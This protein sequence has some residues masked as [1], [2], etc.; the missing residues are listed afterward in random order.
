MSDENSGNWGSAPEPSVERVQIIAMAVLATPVIHAVVC[1]LL[2]TFV[3]LDGRGFVF[4]PE[5][6]SGVFTAGGVALSVLA[7][8]VAGWFR[9]F[10][11][12]TH[13]CPKRAR[14]S[15]LTRI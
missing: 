9:Q 11:T 10:M 15:S 2:K 8:G 3:M 13:C 12:A 5:E 7:V 4:A 14:I 1:F 6:V